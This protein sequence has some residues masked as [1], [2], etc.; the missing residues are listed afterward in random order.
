MNQSHS[1]LNGEPSGESSQIVGVLGD[2]VDDIVVRFTGSLQIAADTESTIVSRQGG[3]GANVAVA[4]AR[5]GGSARFLGQVGDDRRG[6]D[7]V[8]QLQEVGVD[9]Q[10]RFGGTTG[11][12]VVLVSGDGERSFLSDRGACRLLNGFEASWLDGLSVLHVPMYSMH[13]GPLATTTADLV[14]AAHQRG[15]RVTVDAS[16]TSIVRDLG[17]GRV[18]DLLNQLRPEV[19]FC[20]RDEALEL[21]LPDTRNELRI[22]VVV[23]KDGPRPT[24]V[25]V[26][27][28]G[29]QSIV[30]EPID[31]V[32][33]TTGA[34]D[35]FAAGFLVAMANGDQPGQC[36]NRGHKSATQLLLSR[37]TPR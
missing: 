19:L 10:V 22:P 3:S 5:I 31:G 34:G 2:L 4:I 18:V 9:P 36:V 33:D 8:A 14:A 32:I 7:L 29:A 12:I 17:R 15:V 30:P 37:A 21:G 25:D 13:G 16:S 11:S 27:G 23:M 6:R 24:L 35:A 20:N 28:A 26:V 1:A